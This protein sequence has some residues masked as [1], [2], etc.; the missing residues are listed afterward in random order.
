VTN[1]TVSN[2]TAGSQ[3][4]GI[5]AGSYT[6][7]TNSTLSGN[8]APFGGGIYGSPG[9]NE[10]APTIAN[11][12]IANNPSG[13]NC[14][15]TI[16]DDGNNFDD[17][18]TCGPGF[19]PITPDVDFDTELADNGGPTQTHALLEGSVAIDA[20]GDC[21]L[22]TDQRGYPRNDGACDSGSYEYQDIDDVP[23]TTVVG[24]VVLLL[25]VFGTG[26][27]FVRRRAA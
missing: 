2:N 25:T 18:D 17:D 13:G 19:A 6:T 14:G 21:G 5:S 1:S 22:E 3:G 27:Y 24:L 9:T 15:G 26:L 12:I 23:A 8:S 4:G 10:P 20:A 16:M 11:S 7:V